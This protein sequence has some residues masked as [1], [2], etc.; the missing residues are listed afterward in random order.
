VTHI[1]P[2]QVSTY[3][4]CPRRW[5]YSR[6]RPRAPQDER[7]AFRDRAHKVA[8]DWLENAVPP[9]PKTPEGLCIISGIHRLPLPGTALVEH[10]FDRTFWGVTM[11]GRI[12]YLYGY[13]P[14]R[15][16]VIGDHKTTGD[17][18]WRK[19]P[20]HDDPELDFWWDPQRIIYG[21]YAA[22]EWGVEYVAAHWNYYRRDGKGS[23]P[24]VLVESAEGLAGRFAQLFAQYIG[25]M[26]HCYGAPP[27][28]YPR[29]LSNC[30]AFGRLCEFADECLRD[31]SP[32]ERASSVIHS[33]VR[34]K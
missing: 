21:T 6:Q 8:E 23:E 2:S 18:K 13:D 4:G 34:S 28:N 20:G 30:R 12:D 27:E 25:P 7:A 11:T 5:A 19:V 22:A 14:G 9:D 3:K 24:T 29:N 10:R 26:W 15:V 31:V 16:I 17:L 1:S 32:I 33:I